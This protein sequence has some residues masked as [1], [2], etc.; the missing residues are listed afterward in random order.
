MRQIRDFGLGG[1]GLYHYWFYTHQ[2]L[3][4]FER[5]LLQ[6][7]SSELSLV[8]D[9]GAEGEKGLV[10]VVRP[11]LG[12]PT[13]IAVLSAD[14]NS[15]I[16]K[17]LRLYCTVLDHPSYLRWHDRQYHLVPSSA[18]RPTGRSD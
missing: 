4:A 15:R 2:E 14:P 10:K 6:T 5:T 13:P 16:L 18:L 7:P 11:R 1:I 12:D 9:L 8:P 17:A 3:D